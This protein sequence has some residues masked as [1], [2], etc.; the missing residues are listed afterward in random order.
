MVHG[1]DDTALYHT[2][3]VTALFNFMNRLVERMGI[4]LDPSYVKPASERLA[5]RGYLP[6]T[7]AR[8]LRRAGF[9]QVTV[10]HRGME[11]WND[12]GLPVQDRIV[13]TAPT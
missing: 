2:V 7:A 11:Q 9:S 3:A 10:L 12:L 4:E 5:K 6:T 13:A 1:W 8:N